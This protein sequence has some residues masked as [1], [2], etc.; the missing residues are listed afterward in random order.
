M[1]KLKLDRILNW[2]AWN[3]TPFNLFECLK[4]NHNECSIR[5]TRP[6]AGRQ[7]YTNIYKSYSRPK[8]V[9]V[10]MAPIRYV[11]TVWNCI[12]WIHLSLVCCNVGDENERRCGKVP[13]W[14]ILYINDM[15]LL[16]L[17]IYICNYLSQFYK[18]LSWMFFFEW[19]WW[20]YCTTKSR[21]SNTYSL[22]KFTFIRRFNF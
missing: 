18:V 9:R 13:N 10:Y 2:F 5:S 19:F 22:I 20:Q 4:F 15:S 6:V 1:V 12:R 11:D 21:N 7:F 3:G 14:V 17:R 8:K 16:R